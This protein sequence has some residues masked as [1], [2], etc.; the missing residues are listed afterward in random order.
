M[1]LAINEDKCLRLGVGPEGAASVN[2]E[3]WPTCELSRTADQR[4]N[5]EKIVE[6][7]TFLQ[8][9]WQRSS[10]KASY[11]LLEPQRRG[12]KLWWIEMSIDCHC[13]GNSKFKSN[14]QALQ[15][16]LVAE[17]HPPERLLPRA[18]VCYSSSSWFVQCTYWSITVLLLWSLRL[19]KEDKNLFVL[20]T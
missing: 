3:R 6:I 14:A 18:Q 8:N 15:I 19:S 11:R 1:A 17:V 20:I 9:S 10:K 16:G 7:L 4:W 13:R 12:G 5:K 2:F